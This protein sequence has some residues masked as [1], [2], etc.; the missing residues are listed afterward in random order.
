[1]KLKNIIFALSFIVLLSSTYTINAQPEHRP[2]RMPPIEMLK[3]EL[4]LSEAQV[5][6]I[7]SLKQETRTQFE[8]LRAQEGDRASKKAQMKAIR[9]SNKERFEA[10]LTAKQLQKLE[11][12]KA[13]KIAE[14]KE[15]FQA[16]KAD[17][18]AAHKE[19]KAYKEQNILPVLHTQRAKLDR[20]IAASDK[21]KIE[22]LRTLAAKLKAEAKEKNKAMKGKAKSDAM[23]HHK[24]R[25]HK[26]KA[27]GMFHHFKTVHPDAFETARSLAQKYDTQITQLQEELKTKKDNWHNDIKA[28]KEKYAPKGEEHHRKRGKKQCEGKDDCQKRKAHKKG[29]DEKRLYKNIGFLLMPVDQVIDTED[30]SPI[31]LNL[32][33]KVF[34]N[35]SNSTNTLEFETAK[36]GKVRIDIFTQNG[37]YVKTISNQVMDAGKHRIDVNLSNLN[38]KVYYYKITGANGTKSQKFILNNN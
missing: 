17:F 37:Q 12:L 5:E 25:G 14:R 20:S 27:K 4:N 7:N 11:S 10:I 35:P 26:D 23:S 2:H 1:M 22:E 30:K 16:R 24:R 33:S 13:E 6:K 19:I 36:K 3:K 28:I 29:N 21:V 34:P 9:A 8:K 15:K 32:N 18:K 38:E 31:N